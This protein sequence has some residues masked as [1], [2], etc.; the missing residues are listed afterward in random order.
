MEGQLSGSPLRFWW[1]LPHQ[2]V[3]LLR[4]GIVYSRGEGNL[5]GII[6]E[7]RMF[8]GNFA[9]R[10][11]S[12]CDGSILPIASHQAL[13]SILGTTYGGDGRTTFALPDMRGRAAMHEGQGPGL[14]YRRIGE[15][16]GN[17]QADDGS[18]KD[19]V[20][21]TPYLCVNYIICL[22]GIYPS[23]D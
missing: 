20:R 2:R 4:I 18:G 7:I 14:P 12:F 21:T 8:G 10:N 19:T 17:E 13:F 5:E 1:P 3:I 15:T 11:W 16:G 9:P 23:R 22:E 6:A